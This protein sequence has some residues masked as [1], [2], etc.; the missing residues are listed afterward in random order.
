MTVDTA[1]PAVSGGQVLG[2]PVPLGR[3]A[4][5]LCVLAAL[6]WRGTGY[7]AAVPLTM[8]AGAAIA[9]TVTDI[10]ISRIPNGVVMFALVAE[11]CSWPLVAVVDDRAM[12]PL[13]GDLG[14][15]LALSGAPALFVVWLIVPRVLGAA[16]GSCSACS[17]SLSATWRRKRRR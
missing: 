10:R 14:A 6:A 15:G 11:A 8:V 5:A 9:A 3:A 16:T 1:A 2:L 12:L 7:A 4:T 17:G 13:L